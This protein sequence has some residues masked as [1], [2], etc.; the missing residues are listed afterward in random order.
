MERAAFEKLYE[1]YYMRVYSYVMTLA[2]KQD[3]AEEITQ[4][5]FFKAFTTKSVFR[6]DA[7]V[8]TWLCA[9]WRSHTAGC[10]SCGY[11]VSCLS[12][13]SALSVQRRKTGQESRIIGPN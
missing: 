9:S 3:I 5:I 10:L 4:E 12:G 2:K 13:K 7:N 11:S 1:T 6:G 8:M